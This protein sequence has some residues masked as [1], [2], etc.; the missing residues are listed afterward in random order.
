[1]SNLYPFCAR[2]LPAFRA[3][4][5]PFGFRGTSVH[6][7]NLFSLFQVLSPCLKKTTLCLVLEL[8]YLQFLFIYLKNIS[9]I[10]IVFIYFLYIKYFYISLKK[11]F[12]LKDCDILGKIISKF[13]FIFITFIFIFH[14]VY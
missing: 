12:K 11:I 9:D 7:V 5:T 8:L 13:I 14:L 10:F 4:S 2:V 6:P 1:M 3:S